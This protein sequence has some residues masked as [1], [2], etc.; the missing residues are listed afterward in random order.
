MF[1]NWYFDGKVGTPD[2]YYGDNTLKWTKQ[3]QN[4][5]MGQGQ[6]DG[7]IGE[8]TLAKAKSVKK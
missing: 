8:K 7:L 4:E 5:T 3:F 1:L 6:G 2:G